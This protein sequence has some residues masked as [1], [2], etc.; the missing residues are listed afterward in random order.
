[1]S[2]SGR[3]WRRC[4]PDKILSS[5]LSPFNHDSLSLG[6]ILSSLL[7]FFLRPSLHCFLPPSC[8]AACYLPQCASSLESFPFFLPSTSPNTHSALVRFL[9]CLSL[10]ETCCFSSPGS[11]GPGARP[12]VDVGPCRRRCRAPCQWMTNESAQRGVF[13]ALSRFSQVMVGTA[14]L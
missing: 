1:M 11:R 7:S 12:A 10:R 2:V 4:Q 13:A 5:L 14:A 6:R 9:S 3:I 8:S